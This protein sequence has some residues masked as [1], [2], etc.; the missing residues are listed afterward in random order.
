MLLSRD[1][2]ARCLLYLFACLSFFGCIT[3]HGQAD[4]DNFGDAFELLGTEG[5]FLVN[6]L[7]STF[8]E[9]EPLSL[10]ASVWYRWQAPGAGVFQLSGALRATLYT[11][12][13]VS[14]LQTI[15]GVYSAPT[16]T[17]TWPVRSGEVY[18]LAVN[19]GWPWVVTGS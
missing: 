19:Q 18:H 4:N 5:T 9:G 7:D 13:E 17:G 12:S 1:L 8:E 15:E 2:M 6:N 3:A 14:T 10:Y 11:G 16:G